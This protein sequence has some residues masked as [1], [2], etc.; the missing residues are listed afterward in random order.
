M[1]RDFDSSGPAASAPSAPRAGWLQARRRELLDRASRLRGELRDVDD[2]QAATPSV[3]APR[4]IDDAAAQGEARREID[5]RDAEKERDVG[6]LRAIEGALARIELGEYGRCVDCGCTI[7][8]ERLEAEPAAA[9]CVRCEAR[10]EAS[11]A[12]G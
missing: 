6:E 4:E 9:R 11:G 2:E 1:S 12:A 8:D 5:V 3:G 10:R 7:P